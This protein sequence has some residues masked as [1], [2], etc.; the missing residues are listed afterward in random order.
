MTTKTVANAWVS[1]CR[2]GKLNEVMERLLS[3]D[4]VRAS[5]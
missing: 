1:L 3:V 2:Q 5:Q 4:S